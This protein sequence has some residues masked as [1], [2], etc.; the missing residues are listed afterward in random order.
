[1]CRKTAD[2]VMVSY[3]HCLQCIMGLRRSSVYR[4]AKTG[5]SG[6]K[7]ASETAARIKL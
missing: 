4:F 7:V 5:P 2:A 3:P 1:M 6:F